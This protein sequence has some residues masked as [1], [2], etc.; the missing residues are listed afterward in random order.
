MVPPRGFEPLT[1]WFVARHSNSTELRG[2]GVSE[3]YRPTGLR[4]FKPMLYN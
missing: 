2:R 3:W 4:G 1:S